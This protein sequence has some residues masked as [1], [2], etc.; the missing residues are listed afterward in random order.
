MW[1]WQ[2]ANWPNF[3]WDNSITEPLLRQTRLN[4]GVLLGKAT[5]QPPSEKQSRLNTLLANL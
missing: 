2:Q 1:I 5:I 4:Q 3:T